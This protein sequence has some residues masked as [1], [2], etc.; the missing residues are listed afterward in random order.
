MTTSSHVTVCPLAFTRARVVAELVGLGVLVDPA[1]E[2]HE[3]LRHARE[4]LTRMDAGLI[5]EAHAWPAH[6]RHRF[7]VLRIEAQLTRQLRVGL[8]GAPADRRVSS[9]SG[10]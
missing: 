2:C 5:R 10:A 7:E 9:P 1:A 6:Q 4:I 8:A 3:R